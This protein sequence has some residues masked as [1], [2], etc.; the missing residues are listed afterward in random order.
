M[1]D[2]SIDIGREARY[3]V[4]RKKHITI[5][6]D[7]HNQIA[8]WAA[9]QGLNFSSAI[10]SLAL[11]GMGTEEAVTLPALT[12]SLLERIVH[13]QFNRFAHL[14]SQATIAA[15]SANWKADY[16]LL[17]LIRREAKADPTRFVQNMAVSTDPQDPVASRIR[18]MR[19]EIAAAAQ[20]A[21]IQLHTKRIQDLPVL[22][23][24]FNEEG[25]DE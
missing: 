19:D 11:I 8:R 13:R 25:T 2:N 3:G 1:L 14:L 21:A 5:T 4:T 16:L 7:G 15:E 24:T 17:Q 23:E 18:K 10:E 20:M 9:D 12:S 22:T 6:L